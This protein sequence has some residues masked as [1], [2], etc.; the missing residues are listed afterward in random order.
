M[1]G[2]VAV[3]VLSMLFAREQKRLN[4]ELTQAN[5]KQKRL[6][7]ELEQ[8]NE[9]MAEMIDR[10]RGGQSRLAQ[11][12]A[13]Y[14]LEQGNLGE[15]LLWLARS[16]ELALPDD[17]PLREELRTHLSVAA[18]QMPRLRASVSLETRSPIGA[19]MAPPFRAV[20]TDHRAEHQL[21][22]RG[23][24]ENAPVSVRARGPSRPSAAIADI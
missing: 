9:K 16:Y 10:L 15:G 6:Y 20:L 17:S 24:V 14:D 19:V 2:L 12:Q 11:K 5:D 18:E 13:E 7:V 1:L 3:A 21:A 8:T 23:E 22:S 4:Q